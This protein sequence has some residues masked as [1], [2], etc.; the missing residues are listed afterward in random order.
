MAKKQQRRAPLKDADLER[1]REPRWTDGPE[2]SQRVD[3]KSVPMVVTKP[4]KVKKARK[5]KVV[6]D[7]PKPKPKRDKSTFGTREVMEKG[8]ALKKKGMMDSGMSDAEFERIAEDEAQFPD[9][10]PGVQP[11]DPGFRPAKRQKPST[12]AP[13]PPIT[14]IHAG[15]EPSRPSQADYDDDPGALDRLVAFLSDSVRSENTVRFASGLIML[16]LFYNNAM[17]IRLMRLKSTIYITD[18][19]G[20]S[21]Q[22]PN[23]I[24]AASWFSG[25]IFGEIAF[26]GVAKAVGGKSLNQLLNEYNDEMETYTD[27][28]A[29]WEA[30]PPPDPKLTYEEFTYGHDVSAMTEIAQ[31]N[32]AE[33]W[34]RYQETWDAAYAGYLEY[35]PVKPQPPP[36]LVPTT[37]ERIM[38]AWLGFMIGYYPEL[39]PEMIKG[40]GNIISG[41]GEIVPG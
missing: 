17:K 31:A 24:R 7:A 34:K 9:A 21:K 30:I 3:P 12:P 23:W 13:S 25:G 26:R 19:G 22:I 20:G 29:T 40:L 15:G 6:V 14:R 28:L 37:D 32:V 18:P 8:I 27:K 1:A 10:T 2:D 5:Q 35:R 38:Y 16:Y 4:K 39:I 11:G 33:H 36:I 41:I